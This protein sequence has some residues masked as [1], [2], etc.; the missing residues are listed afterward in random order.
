MVE[1][2]GLLWK[3]MHKDDEEEDRE[4]PKKEEKQKKGKE[5]GEEKEVKPVVKPKSEEELKKIDHQLREKDEEIRKQEL[6]IKQ[7]KLE[8][9]RSYDSLNIE[10][11]RSMGFDMEQNIIRCVMCRQW[12]KYNKE[13][14]SELIK[15][16]DVDIIWKYVC[17]ECR[18]KMKTR[19]K[20]ISV[21]YAP[22]IFTGSD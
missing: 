10:K 2:K 8:I 7:K 9:F 21:K 20:K 18:K 6:L 15:K 4:K 11:L 12:I 3:K 16:N 22:E 13:K 14:L 17:T 5:K 19:R 1:L